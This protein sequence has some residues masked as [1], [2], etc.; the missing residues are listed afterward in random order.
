MIKMKTIAIK[1][2]V[3]VF[4]LAAIPINLNANDRKNVVYMN[5]PNVIHVLIKRQEDGRHYF[6]KEIGKRFTAV[7]ALQIFKAY[8]A[9]YRDDLII[10]NI[11]LKY[12]RKGYDESFEPKLFKLANKYVFTVISYAERN[13]IPITYI[14]KPLSDRLTGIWLNI[15]Q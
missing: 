2:I 1:V 13:G 12:H 14:E 10:P 5:N 7:E 4:V 6:I 3:V 15:N 11:I 8:Y 9:S